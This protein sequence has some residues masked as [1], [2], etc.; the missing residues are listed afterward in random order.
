MGIMSERRYRI[1]RNEIHI[2]FWI[3]I[4]CEILE[5]PIDIFINVRQ[6]IKNGNGWRWE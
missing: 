2:V 3:W 1:F 6:S 5:M 4:I